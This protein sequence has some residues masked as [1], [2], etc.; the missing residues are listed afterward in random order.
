MSS[1]LIVLIHYIFL[2]LMYNLYLKELDILTILN[3][4]SFLNKNI[5]VYYIPFNI[6]TFYQR[7]NEN[8]YNTVCCL[9]L[10]SIILIT[11]LIYNSVSISI[12]TS[13]N[14]FINSL[15]ILSI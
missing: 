6:I 14:N 8:I 5:I 7:I 10:H 11:F 3:Q 15:Y 1:L 13:G 12:V 4:T 9:I 2:L